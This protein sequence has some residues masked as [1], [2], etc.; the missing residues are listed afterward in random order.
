MTK[1]SKDYSAIKFK[2]SEA[3]GEWM[4]CL[5]LKWDYE[6]EMQYDFIHHTDSD[7]A[8]ALSKI[9]E[10]ESSQVPTVPI[11]KKV[12]K[13]GFFRKLLLL[14][15]FVALT[16]PVDIKWQKERMDT[17]GVASS[18]F[19]MRFTQE[20]TKQL[21]EIARKKEISSNTLL[22]WA[23]DQAASEILLDPGS[24]RKWVCPINM[25]INEK[26]KYGNNSASIIINAL[27]DRNS[28]T[29]A[30]FQEQI[31]SFL[32]GQLH[33]GS[34][35]Y[36]NMARF[37][38]FSGTLRIAKRIK[39]IGTGVFS[40]M[41]NWP[42]DDSILSDDSKNIT[43]RIFV[44][45]STQVLPIA[46]GAFTWQDK[47]TLSLQIHPS[48]GQSED[49]AQDLAQL[50]LQNLEISDSIEVDKYQWHSFKECP[51]NLIINT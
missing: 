15:K 29:P 39:E 20:Q 47:L 11:Q 38:G 16:K 51:K 22:L 32:K 24:Q 34:Q 17:T 33:W 40:N 42:Q 48:L 41:G 8:S 23:I 30:Q 37:I 14:K 21:D 6:G 1:P 45:P 9:L 46:A 4:N 2:V 12:L 26:Q 50:W 43:H 31:R 7:G 27:L 10:K 13:A 44:A 25:R 3:L 49:R 35:I 18:F 28:S 5:Y 36:S 19:I